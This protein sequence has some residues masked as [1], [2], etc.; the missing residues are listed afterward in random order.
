MWINAGDVI[1]LGLRDYQVCFFVG[2]LHTVCV[3]HG[4][5]RSDFFSGLVRFMEN[6]E[7]HGMLPFHFPGLESH[8]I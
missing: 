7:S 5:K 2:E 4:S 1:L 8:I 3:D 6:L